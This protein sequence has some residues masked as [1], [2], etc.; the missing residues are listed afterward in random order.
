MAAGAEVGHED[1]RA[2][3]P[4]LEHGGD[5]PRH[6]A[7]DLVADLDGG[8][9]GVEVARGERLLQDDQH[10]HQEDEQLD[11]GEG[12]GAL[13]LALVEAALQPR[14]LGLLLALLLGLGA[15]GGSPLRLDGLQILG[16]GLGELGA[17][18]AARDLLQRVHD[19][20]GAAGRPPVPHHEAA[21]AGPA[22]V[23]RRLA[24]THRVGVRSLVG[25]L[26]AADD[27]AG[28][29]GGGGPLVGAEARPL[30][31]QRLAAP[32]GQA[33]PVQ[34]AD[35]VDAGR[36]GGHGRHGGQLLLG[37]GVLDDAGGLAGDH[38]GGRDHGVRPLQ[39]GPDGQTVEGGQVQVRGVLPRPRTQL[40]L[41]PRP[42]PPRQTGVFS[43]W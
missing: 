43:L 17:G 1:D 14:H 41:E 22:V 42:A 19:G 23:G 21:G 10:R 13:R 32:A 11:V 39:L 5:H 6:G 7:R 24:V 27:D 34:A 31:L 15:G 37:L 3:V 12:L 4:D 30:H 35:G 8:D 18:E 36:D 28:G 26:A 20:A 2:H 38:A 9:D 29:H 25:L 16:G 40:R 33:G